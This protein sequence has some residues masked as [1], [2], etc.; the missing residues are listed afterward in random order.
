[1]FILELIKQ[2]LMSVG[3]YLRA[4][5]YLLLIGILIAV[6]INV[7]VD[8]ERFKNLLQRKSRTSILGAVAFGALTPLCA[9]G[10]MAVLLSMFVSALPWGSVMAFLISSPLTSPSEYVFE[11]AFLGSKFATSLLIASIAMGILAGLIAHLLERNTN[12]FKD[13]FRFS[14]ES[15]NCCSGNPVVVDQCSCASKSPSKQPLIEKLKLKQLA[16]ALYELGIKRILLYFIIFIA[17]GKLVELLIPQ[18][19]IITLFSADKFY[20]VPLAA[21]IGLPL[22]LN[23]ASALPLLKSFLDSGASGGAVLAFMIAG[24]ATGVPVIAGMATFIKKRALLFY[25]GFVYFGA[26]A[27]GYL[28][29]IL[30]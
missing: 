16:K 20:S 23:D 24:K 11:T 22:Y 25:V 10:T 9:C 18:A 26:I 28:F 1:M 7:Y 13:Q 8:P 14:G 17:I 29:Q 30:H 21:S 4:D 3:D 5:W 12:F 15:A 27:A 2:I 6:T 19:W